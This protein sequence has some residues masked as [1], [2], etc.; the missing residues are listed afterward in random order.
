MVAPIVETNE[1]KSS[2]YDMVVDV[3]SPCEFSNDHIPEAVNLPVLSDSERAEV[4]KIYKQQSSQ[5]SDNQTNNN[6]NDNSSSE[7][8][9]DADYEVVDDKK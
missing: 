9:K 8:I 2:R 6:S 7:E 3:R 1:W 5:D 4:G